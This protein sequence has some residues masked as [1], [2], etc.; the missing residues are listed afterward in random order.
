VEILS[1]RG[2]APADAEIGELW[3]R[4]QTD[5]H[6]NRHVVAE[7]LDAKGAHRPGLDV[8]AAADILWTLNLSDVWRLLVVERG[9]PPERFERWL[10]DVAASRLLD[11]SA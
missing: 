11:G 10:G 9:W 2:A 1:L 3:R 5:F 4:I 8:D 6:A 7:S